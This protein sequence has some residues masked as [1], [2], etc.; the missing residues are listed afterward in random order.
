M[1][2]ILRVSFLILVLVL[3][4]TL[5]VI[6]TETENPDGDMSDGVYGISKSTNTVLIWKT[7]ANETVTASSATIKDAPVTDFFAAAE[8]FEV[9]VS[10]GLAASSEHLLL[11][12]KGDGIPTENNIVYINQA[13]S[14]ASGAISF[15]D[16]L[17]AYPSTMAEGTYNV[18]IT[19]PDPSWAESGATVKV[20]SY[21]TYKATTGSAVDIENM[22]G[23]AA[24]IKV[25]DEVVSGSAILGAGE[26]FTVSCEK[27]CVVAYTDDGVTYERLVATSTAENNTYQFTAPDDISENGQ[28]VV[29][30][31]G[32]ADESGV[33]DSNDG[34]LVSWYALNQFLVS[35]NLA[36]QFSDEATAIGTLGILAA[37]ADIS[38]TVDTNDGLLICWYAL[39]EFL[40]SNSLPKQFA[41]NVSTIYWN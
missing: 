21:N 39:N 7:A 29:L 32:D 1:K 34:L 31:S 20:A 16:E 13:T 5:P 6:A 15:A 41:D 11:V 28:I 12:V 38:G 36:K 35:N 9:E 26:S 37:D 2:R 18:Y 27:A 8:K 33:V 17:S 25:K 40:S 10:S 14:D 24:I 3:L 30:L 4:L 19:G 23:K 22:A